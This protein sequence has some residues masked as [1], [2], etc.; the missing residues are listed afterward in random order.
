MLLLLFK[1]IT[2]LVVDPPSPQQ[3]QSG[4]AMIT[5]FWVQHDGNVP[6]LSSHFPPK[7]IWG[8]QGA[9][10]IYS[11]R[12]KPTFMVDFGVIVDCVVL[13]LIVD[14]LLN[15]LFFYSNH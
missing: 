1:R 6:S 13:N 7:R 10:F 15:Q 11:T 3:K 5:I 12:S 8:G 14:L 9:H 4:V 2:I